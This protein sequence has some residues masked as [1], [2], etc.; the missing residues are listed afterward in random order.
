[1]YD[2]RFVPVTET[3]A[4]TF[5]RHLVPITAMTRWA[6]EHD[7]TVLLVNSD[8]YLQLAEW[9]VKRLRWLCD[10]G[11]CYI[12]RFNH[13]GTPARAIRETF[14][15]D[16]FL[17]QG[18]HACFLPDSLL[19]MGQPFWDYW[20]P[21]AFAARGMP[22]Y[23][24][25]FPAGF[26]AAHELR[27]SWDKWHHC[28]VEFARVTGEALD[29]TSSHS[30]IAMADRVR[31]GFE[32][33]KIQVAR[34]PQPIVEWVQRT[35]GYAGPKTFVELGS[36]RGTD[37]A[38]MAQLPDVT[39]HALEP[40]PRNDQA[41][42]PNVTVHRAAVADRD[43]QGQLL[44]SREGWGVEWTHSSS[45]KTPKNHLDRFPV[46][47]GE[48]VPV[49]LVALDSLRRRAGF[50]VVDFIW[51]DIEG[52]EGEMIRGGRE[53]LART[54]YLYTEYSDDEM[55]DGQATLADILSLLPDF[56]IVELWE[57]DV[58]LENTS[59]GR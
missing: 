54:R 14:G 26:H 48:H 7:V 46:T 38:W 31:R 18:R 47:F 15:I 9:E 25:E 44:L 1:L 23:S 59:L 52:A 55:Y 4:E 3:T 41:P 45:I 13:R 21:H 50:D 35:F 37:T 28:A 8:I 22:L 20:L 39:I 30:C 36:H 53:T 43:G 42:L 49:E 16:A 10:D 2:V 19:S 11:L 33:V 34:A 12:V 6:G 17:F 56:R 58:L 29:A 51:A 5:G 40:D 27:W 32:N 57:D 24:V